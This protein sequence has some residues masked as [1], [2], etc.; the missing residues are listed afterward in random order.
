M[1]AVA[2]KEETMMVE[3]NR[4][5]TRM[6]RK[7]PAAFG[8][9]VVAALAATAGAALAQ[10]R[11]PTR[12]VRMIVPLAPGGSTDIVA[13]LVAQKLTDALKQTVLVDNRPGG[14]TTIGTHLVAKAQPDGYTLLF[15]SVSLATNA[16]LYSKLPFDT[17]KDFAPIGT[18]GQSFYVLIVQP[19]LG[20]SSVQELIAAAKSKP[21]QLQYASAGQGTITHL[22]VELFSMNAGIK[23]QDVPFKGGAP[24]LV[25]FLGGQM[26]V[27]FS[28]I[29]ECL[30]HLRGG[31][32]IRPLAVTAAKRT[33]DLPDVPT[34]AEA[35]VPKSDVQPRSALYA[36]ARTPRAVIAQVNSELN[37][38]LQQSDTRERLASY[39]LVPAAGTPEDL[40]GYL[41]GE[42]A[43]WTEV[44]K[45]AGI[46]LN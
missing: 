39:G 19:S 10:E 2:T 36:P 16:V 11:Y 35:G 20:V 12:P 31:A 3:R 22:T 9:C 1:T 28:P 27:I 21:K 29:A 23:M 42:I 40:G 33:P 13:R 45:A 4:A 25:A 26:P 24:A 46:S 38:L 7:H 17:L 37:A 34:L 6:E 30:P 32:K 44:V 5:R 15:T 14:G 18:V 43:R 41:R 8:A